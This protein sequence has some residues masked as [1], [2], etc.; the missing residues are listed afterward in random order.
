[1]KIAI[2]PNVFVKET[3]GKMK[4]LTREVENILKIKLK[5]LNNK[6]AE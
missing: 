6:M 5:L 3:T 4:M 2:V 1:M